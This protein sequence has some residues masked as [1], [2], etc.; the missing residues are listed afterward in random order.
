MIGEVPKEVFN[1][2]FHT[3]RPQF[4]SCFKPCFGVMKYNSFSLEHND[5]LREAPKDWGYYAPSL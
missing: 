2:C 4:L 3:G 5:E 1:S